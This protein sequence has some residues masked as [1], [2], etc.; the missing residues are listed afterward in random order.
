[1]ACL[2]SSTENSSS[3]ASDHPRFE[4]DQYDG[5]QENQ[6]TSQFVGEHAQ[7]F[8]H[9]TPALWQLFDLDRSPEPPHA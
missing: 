2:T 8:S 3:S 9:T 6:S 4:E 1:M 7:Q 5:E